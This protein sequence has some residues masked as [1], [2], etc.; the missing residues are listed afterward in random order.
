MS[1]ARIRSIE[2][3]D[4]KGKGVFEYTY[5][6][7]LVLTD[8]SVSVRDGDS[9]YRLAA[10]TNLPYETTGAG[11]PEGGA[12]FR[13]ES[14][15][16]STLRDDLGDPSQG[17]NI[18]HVRTLTGDQSLE[19]SLGDRVVLVDSLVDLKAM[20]LSL[21]SPG[22]VRWIGSEELVIYA[23][24]G[25]GSDANNGLDSS[26]P[27][28]TL[29]GAID[30]LEVFGTY[31]HGQFAIQLA[32]GTYSRGRFPDKGIQSENPII[33]R[34]PDVGGHP[35]VPTAIIS[36]AASGVTADGILFR[37]G[38]R[39]LAK[40]LK[41]IGWDGSTSVGGI[42]GTDVCELWTDNCHFDTCHW[43]ASVLNRSNLDVKG[44]IFDS[45]GSVNG[46]VGTGGGGTRTLFNCRHAI[47]TQNAGTLTLGPI[48]RNCSKA[49][50][51][52][53]GS[54]GHCDYATI[55]DCSRGLEANVNSR[56][57]YSGTSF[58]RNIIDVLVNNSHVFASNPQYGTGA[59]ESNLRFAA[60]NYGATGG[61]GYFTDHEEGN[62]IGKRVY[63]VDFI[64]TLYNSTAQVTV[65]ESTLAAY[66]WRN[67]SFGLTVPRSITLKIYGFLNG[68]SDVKRLNVRL[69]NMLTQLSFTSGDV[70]EFE[71]EATVFFTDR[72]EQFMSFRGYRH[73][74]PA[75][76]VSND[77]GS[78]TLTTNTAL[79]L[80][81]QLFNTN[82]SIRIYTV[83][84]SMNG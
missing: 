18:V 54:T 27:K 30:A 60:N 62:A 26:T 66:M 70:G 25:S 47:G 75:V 21:A 76:R 45:C 61:L 43:G 32:A 79:T 83:E 56:F 14:T 71:A 82:D 81:T 34:G 63:D 50:F 44:G 67:S 33:V 78:E 69:G 84:A 40:D 53:E 52:Q 5:E 51:A 55:E 73:L 46:V 1:T 37:G 65:H 28:A 15:G 17:G 41:F 72:N 57:N 58:K 49:C 74:S 24:A 68:T 42:Q 10:A 13:L 64:N 8:R 11:M 9:V 20:D 16:E 12:F 23:N 6:A 77:V 80:Q 35:T 29:Q 59:D 3:K 48:F 7:G 22:Q 19:N 39:I 38:T 36:E 2:H 4:G 31:L